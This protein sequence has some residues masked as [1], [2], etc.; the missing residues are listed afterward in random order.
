MDR[1]SFLKALALAPVT[2]AGLRMNTLAQ[3]SDLQSAGDGSGSAQRMPVLFLGHGSPMNAIE[4]NSFVQGFRNAAKALPHPTAILCISAHWETQGTHITAMPQ[5]RTIHDF[6]GFPKELYEVQ[7]P[8]PGD[9][10]LARETGKVVKKASIGMD[11]SW[12]LDH[13]AWSV[14]KHMYPQADVPVLQLSLDV[15]KPPQYHFELARELDFLRSRGVLI[16]GSGNIVHNLRRVAWEHLDKKEY[17]FDWS[18]EA[19][20]SMKLH[21]LSGNPEALIDFRSQ[22]SAY[23]LAIPTAEHFLP[24]LYVLALRGKSEEVTLFNDHIVGGSIS[25]TSLRLG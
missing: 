23:D 13:G 6:G 11:E 2:F 8:A 16:V 25:M 22:G 21:I 15:T 3:F 5:P 17:A 20:E 4:E 1:K 24:L 18:I 19:N 14:I 9:P 12:G 7:Y 10:A